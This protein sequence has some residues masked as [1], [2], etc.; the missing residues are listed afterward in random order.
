MDTV[1]KI[2][3]RKKKF[4]LI[5]FIIGEYYKYIR[6]DVKNG[7][8]HAEAG[9]DVIS[10]TESRMGRFMLAFSRKFSST[11]CLNLYHDNDRV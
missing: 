6:M 9:G 7:R 8:H 10:M 2:E 4:A 3:P 1:E 5:P 11:E